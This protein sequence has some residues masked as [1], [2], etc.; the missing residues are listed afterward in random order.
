[1][2]EPYTKLVP[3]CPGLVI[4]HLYSLRVL[5]GFNVSWLIRARVKLCRYYTKIPCLNLLYITTFCGC[6]THIFCFNSNFYTTLTSP[7][8]IQT[9][10]NRVYLI[11]AERG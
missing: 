10:Q 2:P 1:M 9:K 11:I 7:L 8:C 3:K 5:S 4:Y 6:S